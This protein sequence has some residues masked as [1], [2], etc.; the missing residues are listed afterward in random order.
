MSTEQF[1]ASVVQ[2][3]MDWQQT[4]FPA[5]D[6]VYPNGPVPEQSLIS[7]PWIDVSFRP[8]SAHPL[9]VG[10]R[11]GRELGVVS[12]QVFTREGE[13]TREATR[14][15]DSLKDSLSGLRGLGWSLGYPT[16]Y[17][18]TTLQGWYKA[19]SMFPYSLDD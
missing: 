13:G 9:S 16:S 19:G 14:I 10:A 4:N 12:L 8:Y 1:E 6:V 5:T 7:S 11:T 2:A 17:M 15:K 3:I 18:P